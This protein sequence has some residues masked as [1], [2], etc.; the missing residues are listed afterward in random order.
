MTIVSVTDLQ[1]ARKASTERFLAIAAA[2]KAEAG[3]RDHKFTSGLHGH[4][5][6]SYGYIHAPEGRTRK[7]LYILAHE[8]AH[9]A[10]NHSG[11]TKPEHVK[12]M[13]AEKWAH[14]ALRRHGVAVPRAMTVRAKDYVG[15]K[16]KQARLRGAKRI[17]SAAAAYARKT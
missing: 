7:Q 3:V 8:C 4:A 12:E 2:I 11:K 5:F 10:P 13:E 1:A 17:D 6:S 15:R 9:V 14:Q 16:I